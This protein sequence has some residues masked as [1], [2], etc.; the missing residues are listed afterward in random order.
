MVLRL[1][2]LQLFLP[3]QTALPQQKG[4]LFEGRPR[5]QV[6]QP[7]APDDELA[8]LA[9]HPAEPSFQDAEIVGRGRRGR[10]PATPPQGP[11]GC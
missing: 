5:S 6:L 2:A 10:H 8:D 3:R 9:V 1:E 4:D 11:A 7:I